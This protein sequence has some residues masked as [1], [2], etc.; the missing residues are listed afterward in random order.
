[1]GATFEQVNVLGSSGATLAVAA[2]DSS[3]R[4]RLLANY[5][6]TGTADQSQIQDAVNAL[7]AIGGLIDLS[8]GTF[9]LTD[10]VT[11]TLPGI[12]IEGRIGFSQY[13][14]KGTYISQG[15]A[16]KHI[17]HL[18]PSARTSPYRFARM[19]IA[20][21]GATGTGDGIYCQKNVNSLVLEDLFFPT[22][23]NA[24]IRIE[25]DGTGD[26]WTFTNIFMNR[27]EVETNGLYGAY[28]K[29]S[30]K[31][32]DV[33]RIVASHFVGG[34]LAGAGLYI[35]GATRLN[36]INSMCENTNGHGLYLANNGIVHLVGMHFYNWNQTGGGGDSTKSAIYLT[37]NAKVIITAPIFD[38][39]TAAAKACVESASNT[40]TVRILGGVLQPPTSPGTLVAPIIAPSGSK[41][42]WEGGYG[43]GE[44][45]E[46]IITLSQFAD[47]EW[48]NTD[49]AG[50]TVVQNN[51]LYGTLRN[52]AAN[53]CSTVRSH[54]IASLNKSTND[55]Y[56]VNWDQPLRMR[57]SIAVSG[58]DANRLA[59]VQLKEANALGQL[60]EKGIG[61]KLAGLV[62]TGHAYGTGLGTTATLATLTN[63]ASIEVEIVLV[64]GLGVFF[65][66]DG[67][68]IAGLMTTT[69]FPNGSSDTAAYVVESHQTPTNPTFTTDF[70]IGELT[71]IQGWVN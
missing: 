56:S 45:H 54:H 17:F 19:T 1:M 53:N 57:F 31:N 12:A 60:A 62:L 55:R 37:G 21:A 6:C 47:G 25:D 14:P 35:D 71:F 22:V 64:P 30:G 63:G 2:S 5:A 7:P 34:K 67:A 41:V 49:V 44:P 66:V 8:E 18:N 23:P 3:G 4:S 40:G 16:N 68:Q 26:A 70:E 9:A 32:M 52:A 42:T 36:I 24:A 46:R 59:Y 39:Y 48:V 69:Q 28:L 38:P 65:N 43:L 13:S 61:I 58:V 29:Q 15:D 51:H 33:V 27:V 11:I 50:S 20:G 10:E